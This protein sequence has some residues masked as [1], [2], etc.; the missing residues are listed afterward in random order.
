MVVFDKI[1]NR[2]GPGGLMR[3]FTAALL[4]AN[5]FF[6]SAIAEPLLPPGKPAGV[7]QA[8]APSEDKEELLISGVVLVSADAAI[9]LVGTKK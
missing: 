1:M 3:V 7:M 5:F 8:N 2:G 6:P 4:V 9:A